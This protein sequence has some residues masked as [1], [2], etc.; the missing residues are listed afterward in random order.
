MESA[1]PLTAI[2]TEPDCPVGYAF[3]LIVPA[4]RYSS[5]KAGNN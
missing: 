5:K 3:F 2:H 4:C 1:D